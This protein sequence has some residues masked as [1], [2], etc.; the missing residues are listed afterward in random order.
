MQRQAPPGF[1]RLDFPHREPRRPLCVRQRRAA[2]EQTTPGGVAVHLGDRPALHLEAVDQPRRRELRRWIVLLVAS[3]NVSIP[4][5]LRV[6]ARRRELAVGAGRW[7]VGAGG[8]LDVTAIASTG[9]AVVAVGLMSAVFPADYASRARGIDR[10]DSRGAP[11]RSEGRFQP[12]SS[13]S[14]PRCRSCCSTERPSSTARST[15]RAS[16]TSLMR[17]R[18]C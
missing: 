14:R 18:I 16:S 7:A 6:A 11:G 3:A 17:R 4:L 12:G 9:V 1:D 10:L 13:S 15:R 5:M 2:G 8:P